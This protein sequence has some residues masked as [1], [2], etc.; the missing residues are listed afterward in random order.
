M[1]NRSNEWEKNPDHVSF[2]ILS[3]VFLF[4]LLLLVLWGCYEIMKPYVSTIVLAGILAAL[5]GPLNR[6][7]VSLLKGRRNA[8]AL[9]SCV[10]LTLVVVLP[11][12]TVLVMVIQQGIDSFRA[13]QAW[14]EAGKHQ[15]LL[16]VPVVKHIAELADGYF[17]RIDAL[18]GGVEKPELKLKELLSSVSSKVAGFLINQSGFIIGN[19]TMLVGN[20]L[21]MLFV[22]F[23]LVR[24]EDE[25]LASVLHLSP[26]SMSKEQ[27]II[28]KVKAVARSALLGTLLTALAQAIA[29]GIAFWIVG[30]PAAFWALMIGFTSLIPVV[31][32]ALV[33]VPA[34][35]Y[36]FVAGKTGYAI[37]MVVWSVV[38][39]GSIDNFVRPIFMQ[40]SADM[41]S[42]LVFLAILGG[43]SYFGL[44]GLLYGPLL[45]GL[46][47]VLLYIYA[48]EFGSYLDEQDE[49]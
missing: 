33:W 23:F 19:V 22:F 34:A 39:V 7:I 18:V 42:L 15:M 25:I 9:L 16:D 40:G 38:V 17:D 44:I 13:I 28:A 11:L 46:G 1:G 24:D 37:F 6:R 8:A 3:T 4:G 27:Q 35:G 5:F 43:I 32:T 14:V 20:F 47:T 21:L 48:L 30:L 31:G 41:S 2:S 49:M 29:G 10:L 45:V 36:L 26:L 12:F